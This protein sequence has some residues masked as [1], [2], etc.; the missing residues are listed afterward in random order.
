MNLAEQST[1]QQKDQRMV[2]VIL[3]NVGT[4]VCFRTGNPADEKLLLPFFYPYVQPGEI[5]NLPAY[6]F[7]MRISGVKTQEPFS[8]TTILPP[9]EGSEDMARKVVEHSRQTY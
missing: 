8:G 4:L 7:Y 6:N 3:A 2:Q 1:S 9:D 5:S